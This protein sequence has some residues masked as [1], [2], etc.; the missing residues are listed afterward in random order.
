MSAI[1]NVDSQLGIQILLGETTQDP[2]DAVAEYRKQLEAAGINDVINAVN[3]Q[4]K[5]YLSAN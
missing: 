3:E 1:A 4:L 5:D 2:K